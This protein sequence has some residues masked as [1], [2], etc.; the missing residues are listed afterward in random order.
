MVEASGGRDDAGMSVSDR[1]PFVRIFCGIDASVHQF[2]VDKERHWLPSA[3]HA[4]AQRG[5]H[6]GEAR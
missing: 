2:Q 6:H 5:R 3:A 4:G 1:D